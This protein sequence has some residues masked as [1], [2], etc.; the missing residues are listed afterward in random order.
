MSAA[1]NIHDELFQGLAEELLKRLRGGECEHCGRSAAT[2]QE[3]QA[4]RQLLVD[5]GVTASLRHNTPLHRLTDAL[6]KFD[7]DIKAGYGQER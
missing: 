1:R 3:L 7:P 5:N 4:I 2:H 6:P